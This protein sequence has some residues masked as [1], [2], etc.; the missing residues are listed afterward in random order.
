M[1]TA[2]CAAP[3][4][5]QEQTAASPAE[6][7]FEIA[8]LKGGA[9]YPGPNTIAELNAAIPRDYLLGP[10]DV[11]A[12]QVWGE[13]DLSGEH[14]IGP[15]G[16]LALTLIGPQ[17]VASLN[18]TQAT[19]MLRQ[20]LARYYQD[21]SVNLQV[22]QYRNNRVFV[23]GRVENPGV[24]PLEGRGTLL[25]VITRAGSIP[26]A[27]TPSP[28]AKC[29]VIR[30]RDQIIHID[31]E[32]LLHG[33][34]L[35]LNI[36]MAN[37]DVVYIP[38]EHEAVVYVMGEVDA[39]GAYRLTA[40]MSFLDALMRAGG[41]TEDARRNHMAII[42]TSKGHSEVMR[43]RLRDLRKGDL[44]GNVA[45]AENDIIYVGRKGLAHLNY[46]LRQL[47]PFISLLVVHEALSQD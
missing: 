8:P 1:S 39:P 46:F 33:G 29:T 19:D 38:N 22:R 10:G 45:L 30:G 37:G 12:V 21:P 40:D 15:D 41:P 20:A 23:L 44:S 31:L 6:S 14:T 47:D 3:L 35:S 28:L 16:V 2:G 9:P 24:V 26:T 4:A 34:N 13:P 27:G 18:R 11:V 17:R 5:A 32:A 36:D 7:S 25:E 42:R 43:V